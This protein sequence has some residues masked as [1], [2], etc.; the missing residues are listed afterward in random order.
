M[1][2]TLRQRAVA[3][4]EAYNQGNIAGLDDYMTRRLI[5]STVMTESNGGDPAITNKQGYVGR[6]QAGAGWLAEAGY[7]DNKKLHEAMVRD[8][9]DPVKVK[10]AEWKWATA[11]GMT[12]FLENPSNWKEGM[13]LEQYKKSPDLQDQAF[14]TVCDKAYHQSV[15]KGILHEGDSPEKIAGFMKARHIAG[16]GGAIQAM[17]GG[18]V[19]RDSNGTSN[20]D[21]MHDITRDRD[22]LN[23]LMP[24]HL[25]LGTVTARQGVTHDAKASTHSGQSGKA[26]DGRTT[27]EIQSALNQL[28]YKSANGKPLET[29]SGKFGP[30]TEHAV[31]EFQSAHGLKADGVVGPKTLE[32]LK[33]AKDHPLINEASHPSHGMFEQIKAQTDK[34]GGAK[35]LGFHSDKEY[36]Q[37]LANMTWQARIS[38]LTRVDHVVET[39]NKQNLVMIQGGLVDPAQQ[40]EV[41]NKAHAAQQPVAQSTQQLQQDVH[42]LQ[43]QH[44]TQSQQQRMSQAH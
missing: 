39:A 9:Y 1:A 41:A 12:K 13:S 28:G 35:V 29:R 37:A 11:G 15:Q 2:D 23:D 20:Y 24:K 27:I 34:L 5:A 6:Y 3:T 10:G 26:L 21:Y 32:A 44:H 22:K 30:D 25:G 16:P 31:R 8:G 33:R 40:R 38:G 42:Q 7:V 19:V 4:A 43:Q 14:K 36:T 18:R 17:T